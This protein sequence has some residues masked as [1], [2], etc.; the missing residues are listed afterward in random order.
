MIRGLLA[1]FCAV[2]AMGTSIAASGICASNHATALRLHKLQ[3]E[4]ELRAVAIEAKTIHVRGF[5]L[6]HAGQDTSELNG[7][8]SD[9]V[10]SG[11]ENLG[12]SHIAR[13]DVS[14]TSL[15]GMEYTP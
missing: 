8:Q 2:L 11:S 12:G 9:G 7:V 15:S 1:L 13:S 5:S 14:T 3:R 4:C 10:V 6:D